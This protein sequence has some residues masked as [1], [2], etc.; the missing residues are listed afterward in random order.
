[1]VAEIEIFLFLLLAAFLIIKKTMELE[2]RKERRKEVEEN[3]FEGK[4]E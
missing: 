4:E 2:E 1:M 3:L